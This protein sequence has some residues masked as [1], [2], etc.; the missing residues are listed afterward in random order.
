MARLGRL[1]SIA[2]LRTAWLRV[3]RLLALAVTRGLIA[4]TR[5]RARRIIPALPVRLARRARGF[6]GK[7]GR[8][9]KAVYRHFRN[10]AL[11]QAFNVFEEF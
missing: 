11:N 10:L 6:G 8:G 9:H 5:R 2:W 7:V 4:V 3:A 1:L